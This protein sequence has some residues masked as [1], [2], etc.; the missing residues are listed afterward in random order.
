MV[1]PGQIYKVAV[2]I[3][4]ASLPL[5]IRSSIQRN[6]V[7]LS[8]DNKEV[9]EG[10]PETLIMR[11]PPTSVPGDYKLRIEGLYDSVLGGSAFYNETHLTFSQRAMTIF[12]QLEKPIYKQV[13]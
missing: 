5:T 13:N 10:I 2:S 1:R 6:G 9:K 8:S 11:V 7:E 3:L 12:I 4:Q